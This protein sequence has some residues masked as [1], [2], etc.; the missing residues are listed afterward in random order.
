MKQILEIAYISIILGCLA[1]MAV[2]VW[3]LIDG[4]A[5]RIGARGSA[6]TRHADA[7]LAYGPWRW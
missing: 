7:H 2:G 3:H 5:Y 1:L 6:S 4:R